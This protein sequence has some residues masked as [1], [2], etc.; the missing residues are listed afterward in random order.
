M[1]SEAEEYAE[2][3]GSELVSVRRSHAQLLKKGPV[4]LTID[5]H[6]VSMSPLK[7]GFDTVQKKNVS[8]LTTVYD[9]ATEA[10]LKLGEKNPIP[11]LCHREHMNPV[12]VCR[13]CVVDVG[14][15]R[16]APA[17]Q[18]PI[19]EGMKVST[20]RTSTRVRDTVKTLT[21][22][23][24]TDFEPQRAVGVES[25]DNELLAIAGELKLGKPRFPK[26]QDDRGQDTS[27]L[28]IAVDHSAC[29][30][31]DRCVRACNDVRNNQVIGRMGKGFGA[32]IAFDLNTPMGESSCVA[33]GECMVSCPTGALTNIRPAE[34]A[35]D[36]PQGDP[37]PIEELA[38]HE[39]FTDMSPAF[40]RWNHK[41]MALRR[42]KKGEVICREGEN[43]STAF[44][45]LKGKFEVR[46]RSPLRQIEKQT[47][48]AFDFF[49]RFV[50]RLGTARG[51]ADTQGYIPIDAP[52]TL[53]YGNPV[54]VL[55]PEDILFGEM[56]CMSRYPRSATV[57]AVEDCE[58]LEILRNVLYM[59]QRNTKS[60]KI[61]D[62]R[63]REHA[64]DNHLRSVKIFARY[65]NDEQ[66][67][68]RF[69][70]FLR[71]KKT[72]DG[73]EKN[74]VELLRAYPG[75][76]IFRQNDPADHFYMVRVGFVKVSQDRAGTEHVLNYIGPGEYFGE[77]G[78]LAWLS[79][80]DGETLGAQRTATC[81][82]L[83][84]V[85]LVRIARED[86]A[87]LLE[88]FPAVKA[89]L[90]KE[91][92][93]RLETNRNELRRVD[94][95][96]LGDFLDQ[97]LFNAQSLLVL[98]LEKCTR[99][100]ECTKACADAHGGVTRLIR[101]GLRF[102]KFLVASSCRSCLD[103][104]C[105]VGCPVGSIRR[106]ESREIVIEDWCIGC[107]K[108]AENCPYGNINMHEFEEV[109]PD[110]SA[111]GGRRAVLQEK[112]TTCD[113]CTSVGGDPSCVYACPHDAAHRMTGK[114]LEREVLGT[115]LR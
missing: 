98:D 76:V 25:E 16:L 52:V 107:G 105:L 31:C 2:Q 45:M 47:S 34:N 49:R 78:L 24:M 87:E 104:Y 18:L 113:L 39:L 115:T 77:I 101:D 86:F 53:E 74:R 92:K 42:F 63:Y 37:L 102:D 96:R 11:V 59:L 27:S 15:P 106:K 89:G 1:L 79:A 73:R 57:R 51:A 38:K 61:L 4:K 26:R 19:Q 6:E 90:V 5:G 58:V 97:G 66:E 65:L 14:G 67:F 56:T 8:R 114:E 111:P 72:V 10:Y 21:E 12:A 80:L 41:A 94:S 75:Q 103:P 9:A 36:L 112:A 30:L 62:D 7:E 64:L 28:V 84:H 55:E 108:C 83:D 17:C 20:I 54:A 35:A 100:D 40:L 50:P 13:M 110:P 33:C 29:I 82:A 32:R 109:V 70:D 60:K 88:E 71:G 44:V 95:V 81:S 69:A 85:D 48:G 68:K 99:C 43:G 3:I 91:A 22:L 23:L 93:K 46:I